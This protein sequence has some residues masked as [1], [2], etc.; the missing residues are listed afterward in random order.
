VAAWFAALLMG[1]EVGRA[2]ARAACVLCVLHYPLVCSLNLTQMYEQPRYRAAGRRA[3]LSRAAFSFTPHVR[4]AAGCY[5][6]LPS[7]YVIRPFSTKQVAVSYSNIGQSSE[8]HADTLEIHIIKPELFS[9]RV[10]CYFA[11]PAS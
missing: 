1:L 2:T 7:Y 8:G 3:D 4:A 6:V 9:S 11:S 5:A 10:C